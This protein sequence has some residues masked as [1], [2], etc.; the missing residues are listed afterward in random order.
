M[1]SAVI[2]K[3]IVSI[4]SAGC[5][6]RSVFQL[7]RSFSTEPEVKKVS[8]KV[9]KKAEAKRNKSEN[10]GNDELLSFFDTTEKIFT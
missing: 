6:N 9:N 1:K 3:K 10:S 7:G 5:L 4:P 8:K 2:L